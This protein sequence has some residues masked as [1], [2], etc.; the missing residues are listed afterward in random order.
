[1]RVVSLGCTLWLNPRRLETKVSPG[2]IQD[3]AGASRGHLA[4]CERKTVSLFRGIATISSVPT[5]QVATCSV[6]I[7]TRIR[8][9]ALV[10]S[11]AFSHAV[12]GASDAARLELKRGDIVAFVGGADVAA[13]QNTGHLET[14]LAIQ[15]PGVRFRNFGGEG[16]T[17]FERPRMMGF[18]PLKEHLQRAKASVVI[19]QFGRAEVLGGGRSARVFND[20]YEKLL[21]DLAP[22][23]VRFALVVPAPFENA[24]AAPLPDLSTRNRELAE[25][26]DTVR[27]IAQKRKLPVIDL[28][29]EFGGIAHR[30]PLLTR[31][32]L[33]LTERGEALVANAFMR[34]LGFD[35]L[36]KRAGDPDENGGWPN[37]KFERVRRLVVAK[38]RLWF[39]YWR[40]HNWAF[41]GGDRVSQPSSRDH[42]DPKIR[43][44]PEEM[45]KFVPLIQKAEL[46]IDEAALAAK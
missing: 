9:V 18:P 26:A 17:V 14:L 25:H 30:E 8:I 27:A 1:M 2:L 24:G 6:L 43:W 34:Q 5:G 7:S 28:F 13:A 21:D 35:D 40:P 19:L 4:A 23:D 46:E 41:L 39:D 3:L 16:D 44:F 12:H 33:Q 20:A 38:N 36:A 29:S 31:N 45:E 10:L 15:F 11:L 22:L 32:G 42:R 37:A